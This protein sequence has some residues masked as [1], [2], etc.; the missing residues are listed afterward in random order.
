MNQLLALPVGG[1]VSDGGADLLNRVILA[2]YHS[3]QERE[4]WR[5]CLELLVEYFQVTNAT[6]VLR[7]STALDLGYLVCMPSHAKTE[8]EYRSTWYKLDPFLEL[9]PEQVLTIADVMGEDQW[10]ACE[11]NRDFLRP[12]MASHSGGVMGVN[13]TTRA[14]TVSRLRLHRTRDLPPFTGEEKARLAVLV[15][16]IKQAM[17]LAAQVNRNESEREIYEEGLDRLNIGVIVLDERRQLLRANPVACHMLNGGDGVRLVERQLEGCTPA[18]TRDLRR[19]L[20]SAHEYPG[21]VTAMSLS[22][23]QGRRKLAAVV[24][25]IPLLEESEARAQPAYAVFLRDPDALAIAAQDIARQL[26]DFTPAE[27]NL[28]IEL[29]NGLS[30]DEAAEKLGIR[31]NTVRAHLRAIFSKAGVTRQSELVRILLNGVLGLSYAEK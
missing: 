11:F 8:L 13:I 29:V 19:L 25:S 30:L 12:L 2:I 28:A 22:R 3:V 4:P 5:G 20:D 10:L 16:H 9:P 21:T 23:P 17:T 31:R 24:R 1:V 27:A 15:P 7:P 14:G 18:D 6:F 26:F